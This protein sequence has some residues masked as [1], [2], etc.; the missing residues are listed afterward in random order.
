MRMYFSIYPNA[1]PSY[2]TADR[3]GIIIR[4]KDRP[5]LLSRAL[6]SVLNQK[7]KNW[8]VYI[9]ND[10]GDRA[11]VEKVVDQYKSALNYSYRVIHR[12]NSYGMES[13]SNAALKEAEKECDFLCIHDDDDSWHTLFLEEC[14]SFLKKNTNTRFAAVATQFTM[15]NEVISGTSVYETSRSEGF[16]PERLRFSDMVEMNRVPPISIVFRM[17]A[18]KAVGY[19]NEFLPVLGD[20][21]FHIRIFQ[22]GDIGVIPQKLAY[23]HHR[24]KTDSEYGNTVQAGVDKH[25]DNEVLYENAMVRALL[26]EHPSYMAIL[27]IL[28]KRMSLEREESKREFD[29]VMDQLKDTNRQLSQLEDSMREARTMVSEILEELY[30]PWYK[31]IFKRRKKCVNQ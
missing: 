14:I 30:E 4:T 21:D 20:W 18:V 28:G 12:I 13:A 31:S 17:Q 25:R 22:Y 24:P 26:T 7:Y 2:S 6:S 5:I 19:F 10:C 11:E 27:R 3:V 29:S 1:I 23:Y 8:K 16:L 15:I 9:V